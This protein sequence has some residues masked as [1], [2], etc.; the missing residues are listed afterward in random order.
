MGANAAFFFRAEATFPL[1]ERGVSYRDDTG[2]SPGIDELIADRAR[3]VPQESK[4][5][6]GTG[7]PIRIWA[8]IDVPAAAA[9]RRVFLRAGAWERA[10]YFV[11]RDGRVEEHRTAGTLEPWD[12]RSQV[13]MTPAA[14]HA[15]LVAV[16]LPAQR[17]TTILAR[18]STDN[19]FVPVTQLRFSLWDADEVLEGERRDRHF[20]GAY[21]AVMLVLVSCNLALFL[22][23]R[24]PGYL[25]CGALLLGNVFAQLVLYGQAR[26]LLWPNRPAWDYYCLWTAIP[27]SLWSLA[28]LGRDYLGTRKAPGTS[29]AWLR[30]AGNAALLL[31]A[32]YLVPLAVGHP[33][34][35]RLAVV[36]TLLASA[37]VIPCVAVAAIR[38]ANGAP[39]GRLFLAAMLC[40]G[41]G[42]LV[43]LSSWL[44][45]LPEAEWALDA[46]EVGVALAAI[47]LSIGL[48]IGRRAKP[49]PGS[50]GG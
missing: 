6:R 12:G 3:W 8:R 44:G 15:G 23:D 7:A 16:D 39:A 49:A 11:V 29:D 25:Y 9:G 46:S 21:L 47:L 31:L 14:F 50:E 41:I 17:P 2:N 24:A 28:Q 35:L 22:R 4:P 42:L 30:W 48:A 20:Q 40:A 1:L 19:R 13:T 32:G 26:E 5:F 38:L 36:G 43:T 33:I 45:I 18:L 37:A 27:V 34:A 10:E